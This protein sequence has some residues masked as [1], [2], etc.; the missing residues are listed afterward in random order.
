M[1]LGSEGK[2]AIFEDLGDSFK[3]M[4][5]KSVELCYKLFTS[6]H[7]IEMTTK[8]ND[9]EL[10]KQFPQWL[11]ELALEKKKVVVKNDLDKETLKIAEADS[12]IA[13]DY[14]S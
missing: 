4:S 7:T 8:D 6:N 2:I 14:N 1:I 11:Q 9:Y 5:F 10:F 13:E 12:E 3:D